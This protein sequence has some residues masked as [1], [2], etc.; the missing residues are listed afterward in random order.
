M[1]NVSCKL[2]FLAVAWASGDVRRFKLIMSR[3]VIDPPALLMQLLVSS[4]TP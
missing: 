1:G 4:L 2:C 3:E